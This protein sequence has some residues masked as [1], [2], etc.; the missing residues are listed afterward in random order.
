MGQTLT[1]APLE[2]ASPSLLIF[3][4]GAIL[5]LTCVFLSPF[6]H[7]RS[8]YFPLGFWQKR[9]ALKSRK[10]I[11]LSVALVLTSLAISLVFVQPAYTVQKHV[12][13]EYGKPVM[14]IVDVSASMGSIYEESLRVFEKIKRADLGASLGLMLYSN[15]AYI[16]RDF[17]PDEELLNDSLDN[18]A[19][20]AEISAGTETAKAISLARYFFA[21]DAQA[22]PKTMILVS[23]L[24]DALYAVANEMRQA[25]TEGVTIYVI[26]IVSDQYRIY[27]L[28]QFLGAHGAT[29]VEASDESGI[30]YIFQKIQE[31]EGSFASYGDTSEKK[32]LTGLVLLLALG[33]AGATL[34]LSETIARKIP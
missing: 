28:R 24:D 14:V 8:L 22:E 12:P 7:K 23:D 33:L 21:K 9:V 17:A 15:D 26:A 20:V 32:D 30:D 6:G 3:I 31:S 29:I 10:A 19:E 16:A 1:F 13:A 2:L 5:I 27:E 11:A 18:K 4:A 25:I 34:L